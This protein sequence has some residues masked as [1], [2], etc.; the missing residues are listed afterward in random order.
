LNAGYTRLVDW[1]ETGAA[2]PAAPRLEWADPTTKARDESGNALG[3]IRLPQHE[4]ATALNHGNNSGD[5]FCFLFGHHLPFDQDT[6]DQLY[7]THGRY[8]LQVVRA[9]QDTRRDGYLL[10][11]DAVSTVIDAVRSGIGR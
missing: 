1:L 8:V 5:G 7:P 6:L 2:P 3:G 4:A 11:S 9:A 10:R